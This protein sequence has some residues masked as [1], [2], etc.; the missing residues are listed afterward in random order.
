MDDQGAASVNDS[1]RPR[2]RHIVII[3]AGVAGLVAAR[4]LAADHEVVVLDKG[5]YPGGRLGT[6]DLGEPDRA[7]GSS[8]LA[9]HGAQF[10][11]T[12][13]AEFAALVAQWQALGLV[14]PWFHGQIGPRGLPDDAPTDGHPRYRGVR[15]MRAIAE[16]LA[17]GLDVRMQTTVG[18]I[19]RD[20]D[21]W[22][23]DTGPDT[24]TAATLR[25]DALILTPPVP[26]S[27]DLLVA[28]GTEL[29][30]DDEAALRA[31]RYDPCLALLVP[32]TGPSGLPEP[33]AIDPA[34]G[35]IEWL[36]DNQ[37]KGISASPVLTIHAD[38]P[39][40]ARAWQAPIEDVATDLLAAARLADHGDAEPLPELMQL[41]RW[42]YARPTVTHSGRCLR[43][44]GV[45]PLVF[46]GDGFGEA[47]VEG[48]M[49]SGAEAA[50]RL[51]S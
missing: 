5:R 4:A 6:R 48:A 13:T 49:L 34:T 47:K 31:V 3:G 29:A 2:R 21:G 19:W 11:T 18:A 41:Q 22:L 16:Q 32:L 30:A 38:A 26:Q 1:T 8:L 44:T 51:L 37:V 28:G 12:H 40:S 7:P 15:S 35:P 43:A 46:A 24:D 20:G 36:A 39:Y 27:L 14:A 9:D 45:P 23:V 10:I 25:A 33:G 42:R 17:T 50:R